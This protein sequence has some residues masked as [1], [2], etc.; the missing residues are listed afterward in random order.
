MPQL[1]LQG[2]YASEVLSYYLWGQA[3]APSPNEIADEKWIH[4]EPVTLNIDSKE[5]FEAVY[6]NTTAADFGL[7]K[8]FFSGK[9]YSGQSIDKDS[10]KA[11][12]EEQPNGEFTINHEDFVKIF[13]AKAPKA[14][15][16]DAE[17]ARIDSYMYEADS[18]KPNFAKNAF[19]FGS[20]K[21]ELD[22]ETIEYVFDKDGNPLR[23][24]NFT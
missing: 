21:L 13:Y 1:N 8:R 5:Y 14:V 16:T 17:N 19:V 7:I 9:G 18:S 22:K 20:T 24:D 4:H 23:I 12:T 10:I 2:D 3:T 11:L 15:R 6:D